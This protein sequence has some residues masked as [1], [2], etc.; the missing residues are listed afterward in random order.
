MAYWL[1]LHCPRF[2]QLAEFPKKLHEKTSGAPKKSL[3]APET[4]EP[5]EFVYPRYMD[6]TPLTYWLILH[7]PRFKQ[8]AEFSKNNM[9]KPRA[10]Q[11]SLGAPET[12]RPLDFVDPRYMDVTPLPFSNI[13]TLSYLSSILD[14]NIKILKN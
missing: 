7:C 10:S 9:E 1:V 14:S 3:G 8:L 6:V 4:S 5:L 12:S 2:K 13:N 11:K